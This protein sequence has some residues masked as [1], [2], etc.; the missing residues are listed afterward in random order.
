MEILIIL[1]KFVEQS[2]TKVKRWKEI[3]FSPQ[4]ARF[5]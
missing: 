4:S 5:P 3:Y 1:N 2:E